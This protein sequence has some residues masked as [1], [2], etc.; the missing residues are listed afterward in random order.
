M[1][2]A[3]DR[4]TVCRGLAVY[5]GLRFYVNDQIYQKNDGECGGKED[6][7]AMNE[8][9]RPVGREKGGQDAAEHK[10]NEEGKH[11]VGGD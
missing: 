3:P 6:L 8:A 4:P 9:C 7:G 2:K 11:N 5:C 1:E 10:V